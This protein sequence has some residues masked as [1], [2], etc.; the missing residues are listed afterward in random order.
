MKNVRFQTVPIRLPC[1]S[2]N[3]TLYSGS[4][5]EV[6]YAIRG[7]G[8][9]K[10]SVG[11]TTGLITVAACGRRGTACIDYE[12][13]KRFSLIYT[14]TDGG[15]QITTTSLIIN[16]EDVNDNHPEFEQT[17]YRRVVREGD[18]KF[19]PPLVIKAVDRDGPLQGDGKVFYTIKS[20]NTDAVVFELDP[21]TGQLAII[22]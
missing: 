15:G 13:Q 22:R 4:Y 19:E 7:F 2:S 21:I 9:E 3:S 8:K 10:F 11:P 6:V 5:G 17:E 20:I 12:T 14:A 18:A 16:I 1:R